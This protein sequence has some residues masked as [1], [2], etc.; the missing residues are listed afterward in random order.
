MK[1]YFLVLAAIVVFTGVIVYN[2][3][4]QGCYVF[5][6]T[7]RGENLYRVNA[8][9]I[10]KVYESDLEDK[11]QKAISCNWLY[12]SYPT[13]KVTFLSFKDMRQVRISDSISQAKEKLSACG[14]S[15][16]IKF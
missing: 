1:Y 9:D 15:R 5:F 6:D 2:H 7:S 8:K 3:K 11:S 14:K 12:C 13:V 16:Q 10:V 4:P